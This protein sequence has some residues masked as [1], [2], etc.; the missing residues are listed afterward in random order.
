MPTRREF[1]QT[2]TAAAVA[3]SGWTAFAKADVARSPGQPQW[4]LAPET[5]CF[6]SQVG[7]DVILQ[8]E[9]AADLGFTA[10][11]DPA[12]LGRPIAEQRSILTRARELGLLL[13]PAEFSFANV[14]VEL[15]RSFETLRIACAGGLAGGR[16]LVGPQQMLSQ[17]A[18]DWNA[19]VRSARRVAEQ[20]QVPLVLEAWD[21]GRRGARLYDDA[22]AWVAAVDHPRLR[23]S[24][25]TVRLTAAGRDVQADA[26][27]WKTLIGHVETDLDGD[28]LA[29][30]L[31][32]LV[33]PSEPALACIG[34]RG[35]QDGLLT[36]Q[37]T[38][39]DFL[40]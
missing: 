15:Q 30:L 37:Q 28:P 24:F 6:E 33:T 35:S 29:R 17:R 10:F 13:G 25:D 20:H 22:A 14:G 7:P 12:L 27:Q 1:L 16:I 11:L 34:F 5:G 2:L 38:T 3:G 8:M 32:E 39:G 26:H 31:D 4:R 19:S 9:H 21:D 36:M 18:A 40:G 23:L